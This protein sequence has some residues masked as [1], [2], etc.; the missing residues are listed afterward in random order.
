MP[1]PVSPPQLPPRASRPRAATPPRAL[2]SARL[3][4]PL[5]A[6]EGSGTLFAVKS[7]PAGV[8]EQLRREGAILSTLR[9]PHVL[10][11]L[12][13]RIFLEFAPGGSLADAAA[14]CAGGRLG[15]RVVRAY[16][17][18]VASGLAYLHGCALVHGDVKPANVVVGAD[19]RAKLA[20]F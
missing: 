15:E 9:S 1:P 7:A 16:A 12:G 8:V 11:C 4:A 20:D 18:D 19:G 2:S 3:S 17:A 6:D 14:R 10:P 13:F 5:A